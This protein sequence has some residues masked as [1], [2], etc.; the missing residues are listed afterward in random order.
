MTTSKEILQ[1]IFEAAL[2][3][4]DP[5]HPLHAPHIERRPA[6]APPR[7]HYTAAAGRYGSINT[8]NAI[9]SPNFQ[10]TSPT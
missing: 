7:N 4:P 9:N 10:Q 1:K 5:S 2:K 8:G 6:P 3:E